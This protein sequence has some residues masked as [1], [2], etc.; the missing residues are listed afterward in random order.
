MKSIR[1]HSHADRERVVRELVPEFQRKFGDNLLA[2]AAQASFG[3]GDDA[4]YSDL[5][6][7]VFLRTLPDGHREGYTSIIRDGLL[8]EIWYTTRENYL[9]KIKDVTSEWYLAGSD[10][11]VP[12][13]NAPFLEELRDFPTPDLDEKCH[14]RLIR[15]WPGLQE[16]VS[17]TL[18]AIEQ[19][20]RDGLPMVL[21]CL[22]NDAMIALS[23]LNRRPYT[24]LAKFFAEVRAFPVKPDRLEDFLDLMATGDYKDLAKLRDVVVGMFE[25]FETLF[26]R[27]GVALTAPDTAID[28]AFT[29][30]D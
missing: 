11:L 22:M 10:V 20:N 17:K 4:A 1:P 16:D 23:F 6:I 7:G 29:F 24:T 28:L 8:I 12:V 14:R 26:E 30:L 5:E 3:R 21:F 2:I 19:R 13:L 27:E 25:G 15:L 9:A 18:N